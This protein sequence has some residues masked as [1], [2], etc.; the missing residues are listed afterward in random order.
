MWLVCSGGVVGEV[1]YVLCDVGLCIG[2]YVYVFDVLV[3]L[4]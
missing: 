2:V 3:E 1:V 4:L